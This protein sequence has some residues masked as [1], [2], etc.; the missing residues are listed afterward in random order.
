MSCF[1][2]DC[3]SSWDREARRGAPR[4]TDVIDSLKIWRAGIRDRGQGIGD[5]GQGTKETRSGGGD[6]GRERYAEYRW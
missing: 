5:R 1:F 2:V 4:R 3:A 6:R